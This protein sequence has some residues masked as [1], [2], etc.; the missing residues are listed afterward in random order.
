MK[1]RYIILTTVLLVFVSCSAQKVEDKDT[2]RS[3]D[4]YFGFFN[5]KINLLNKKSYSGN[6]SG[7]VSAGL[8]TIINPKYQEALI[9]NYQ[10]PYTIDKFF[11]TEEHQN[12]KKQAQSNTSVRFKKNLKSA[13][14]SN[15]KEALKLS[16]PVFTRNKE[17]AAMLVI[18]SSSISVAFFKRDKNSWEYWFSSMVEIE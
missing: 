1:N 18:E 2:Y 15:N 14:L 4:T 6:W 16:L 13:T 7:Y 5:Q 8:V 11:T 3:I 17:K 9:D 10:K 12:M